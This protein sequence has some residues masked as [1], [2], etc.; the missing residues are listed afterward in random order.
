MGLEKYE[1]A[2]FCLISYHIFFCWMSI[3][4]IDVNLQ[5]SVSYHKLD[6]GLPT[7]D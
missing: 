2:F 6:Y 5:L 4:K 3:A 7:M 1:L